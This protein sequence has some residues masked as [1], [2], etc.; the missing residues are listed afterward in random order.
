MKNE[1]NPNHLIEPKKNILKDIF[2][3]LKRRSAYVALFF[4]FFDSQNHRESITTT[5]HKKKHKINA[6][7][8]QMGKILK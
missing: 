2:I 5:K 8:S 7:K 3:V 1:K 4:F 6:G